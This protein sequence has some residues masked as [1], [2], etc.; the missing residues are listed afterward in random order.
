M[1]GDADRHPPRALLLGVDGGNTKTIALVATPDGTIVGAGRVDATS[2]IYAA[3]QDQALGVIDDAAGLALEAAAA[4]T[5]DVGTAAFSLAGADWPED[6]AL[7]TE[8]LGSRWP[9]RA[10]VNDAIG[11]L[12]AAILDGPG[13]V[14]ACG[15]GTAT[16]AR[17]HDGRTWHTSFWQEPQGAL[18]LG[19]I[20]LRAVY[21]AALGIDEPTLLTERILD[22]T[23]EADVESLLHHASARVVVE[24]RDPATLAP[25]LLDVAAAGDPTAV[26][27]VTRH[28]AELG[29]TALAAARRVGL[30]PTDAFGL[31]MIGGV[32]RHPSPGLRD[33]VSA[34]VRAAAPRV[35]VVESGLEPAV[36]ALL[37]AFDRAAI[38]VD[39]LL[40]ERVRSSLPGENLFDTHPG[41]ARPA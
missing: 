29:R 6:V 35:H 26:D 2:D 38:R 1:T 28:G 11:A 10:V 7:L 27:I 36:G 25:I 37:L 9:A 16:G 13:V 23:G 31:A 8:R 17:G 3:P 4:A 33:A 12:R 20:A 19:I 5:A 22:A 40:L 34:T 39:E 18:E 14:V 41:R 15:T 30:A 21:R 24:R 32:I